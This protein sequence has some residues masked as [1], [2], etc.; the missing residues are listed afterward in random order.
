MKWKAIPKAVAIWLLFKVGE[1]ENSV[2]HAKPLGR[3]KIAL[4]IPVIVAE[5]IVSIMY[6]YS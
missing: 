3:L 6:F 1:I 5:Y 2:R 4:R